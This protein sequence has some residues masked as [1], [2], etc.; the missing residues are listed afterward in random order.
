MVDHPTLGS[1]GEIVKVR[2]AFMRNYLHVGNKACYTVDGPRIP[3][4]EASK[5]SSVKPKEKIQVV[6]P[7]AAE[8]VEDTGA[9][10]LNELS[11]LFNTM[12]SSRSKKQ[13][14]VSHVTITEE[15]V[16]SYTSSELK[17][18]PANNTFALETANP[19]TKQHLVKYVYDVS[20]ITVSESLI[21][22]KHQSGREFLKEIDA[23]GEYLWVI[24]VP[25]EQTSVRRS[26]TIEN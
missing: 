22:L 25:S 12:R 10:S 15:A 11:N 1:T 24:E 18:I 4:V 19:L 17:V 7:K 23:V 20:G 16:E 14:G 9:M 21:K 5:K 3:V 26:I 13:A 8:V 2:P 6:E